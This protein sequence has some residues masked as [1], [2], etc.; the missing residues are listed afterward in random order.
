MGEKGKYG[1]GQDHE[2]LKQT[3]TRQD[4]VRNDPER[5]QRDVLVN[6]NI[7]YALCQE[8]GGKVFGYA[9]DMYLRERKAEQANFNLIFISFNLLMQFQTAKIYLSVDSVK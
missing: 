5:Q 1:A 8:R 3:H 7:C 9:C 2:G 4:T 6:T